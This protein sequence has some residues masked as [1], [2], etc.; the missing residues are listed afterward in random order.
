M[1]CTAI[2]T[3]KPIVSKC[4]CVCNMIILNKH[5]TNRDRD[6]DLISGRYSDCRKEPWRECF[7]LLPLFYC[8]CCC[9]CSIVCYSHMFQ[10]RN[11][12][13]RRSSL[14]QCVDFV[15]VYDVAIDTSHSQIHCAPCKQTHTHTHTIGR[16]RAT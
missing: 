11:Q 6:A 5:W 16:Q 10:G 12:H 3:Q 2:N 7:F 9:Y 8:C 1:T 13:Y 14:C 4:V 15:V